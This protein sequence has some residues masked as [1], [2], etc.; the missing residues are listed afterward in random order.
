MKYGFTLKFV[1]AMK[2]F[3]LLHD[4][5]QNNDRSSTLITF[6]KQ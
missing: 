2:A 3:C 5:V 1:E 6:L 4:F